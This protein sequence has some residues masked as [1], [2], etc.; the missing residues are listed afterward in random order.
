[1][2]QDSTQHYIVELTPCYQ[3]YRIDKALCKHRQVLEK[4][5]YH[6]RDAGDHFLC[7]K[8]LY[9]RA[10]VDINVTNDKEYQEIYPEVDLLGYK[11]LD[12]RRTETH[13]LRDDL[14]LLT[15]Q[16]RLCKNEKLRETYCTSN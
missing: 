3:E 12:M 8:V 14:K 16:G 11:L 1:M 13:H 9:T 15:Y 10:V 6:V 7:K 2:I 5:Y 4:L